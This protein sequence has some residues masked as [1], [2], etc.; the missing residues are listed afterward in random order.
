MTEATTPPV[1]AIVVNYRTFDEVIRLRGRLHGSVT[2]MCVVDN[3]EGDD[4][5]G[6]LQA[7]F[8]DDDSITL[9][10]SPGN[11]G[12]AT[13]VN[14]AL[15]QVTTTYGL[16]LNPDLLDVPDVE[17]LVDTARGRSAAVCAPLVIDD[18][19]LRAKGTY[20]GS[21]TWGSLL[22]YAFCLPG[23][24]TTALMAA[25]PRSSQPVPVGWV[26]GAC[27]LVDREAWQRCR[28]DESLFLYAEDIDF[29]WQQRELGNQVVLD[30]SVRVRHRAGGSS[31]GRPPL[32]WASNLGRVVD[33]R[34][35]GGRYALACGLLLRSVA[36]RAL[37]RAEHGRYLVSSARAA[38]SGA[39]A[40]PSPTA[41][42]TA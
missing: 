27:C 19:G 4:D 42:S 2:A 32:L 7:A 15:E 9:M 28:F 34:V 33:R 40:G 20:G 17:R 11:V 3:T 12:F 6:N 13:A 30:P 38:A 8:R 10:R 5:W 31:G 25:P 35:R 14:S 22:R 26:S 1:T 36:A 29:C 23:R 16:L 41:S 39:P 21:P 37:G 18:S 24:R